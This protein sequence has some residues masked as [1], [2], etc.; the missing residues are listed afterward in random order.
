MADDIVENSPLPPPAPDKVVP[1][2][3]TSDKLLGANGEPDIGLQGPNASDAAYDLAAWRGAAGLKGDEQLPLIYRKMAQAR[4]QGFSWDE[5]N[6]SVN[7]RKQAAQEAGFSNDEINRSL[8]GVP[9]DSNPPAPQPGFANIKN[10]PAEFASMLRDLSDKWFGPH[11]PFKAMNLPEPGHVGQYPTAGGILK[12]L[13]WNALDFAKTFGSTALNGVA[14]V[15]ESVDGRDK[16]PWEWGKLGWEVA[17]LGMMLPMKGVAKG[18]PLP[19]PHEFLDRA[20]ELAKSHPTQNVAETMR[21]L[22]DHYI[23][24]G[25]HPQ[26]VPGFA[27]LEQ[28]LS[29]YHGSPHDFTLF[30]SSKALSG[31]GSQAFGAGHYVAENRDVG[32][33]YQDLAAKREQNRDNPEYWAK[34]A[35]ET[36]EGDNAK[37]ATYARE[38]ARDADTAFQG[39]RWTRAADL[40]EKN[41]KPGGNLYH[42]KVKAGAGELM[43]WDKPLSEQPEILK[44]INDA[45]IGGGVDDP[46]MTGGEWYQ[47]VTDPRS[48]EMDPR[49]L[50][51]QL[52][53]AGIPGHRFLDAGSRGGVPAENATRNM[54]IYNDNALEIIAKNGELVARG[55]GAKPA[56]PV[57]AMKSDLA[58]EDKIIPPSRVDNPVVET[59]VFEKLMADESGNIA[60]GPRTDIE[61]ETLF[62]HDPEIASGAIHDWLALTTPGSLAPNAGEAIAAKLAQT[63]IEKER[64]MGNIVRFGRAVGELSTPERLKL[65]DGIETGNLDEYK[66]KTLG[67]F[68]EQLR[69]ELDYWH[70]RITKA[71]GQLGYVQD[72]LPHIYAEPE[73]A[74]RWFQSRA[75]LAGG[76]AFTKERVFGT[77]AEAREAGLKM[78]SDNPIHIS[79]VAINQMS[80]YAAALD[81]VK[82]FR[83]NGLIAEVP[84]GEP[85][86]EGAVAIN[87]RLGVTGQGQLYAPKDAA[88]LINNITDKGLARY[89]LY[90][91]LRAYSNSQIQVQLGLSGYH[92]M[93][94]LQDTMT[95]A[96]AQ[97]V[98]QI[99]RGLMN[100]PSLETVAEIPRGLLTMAKAPLAPIENYLVGRQVINHLLGTKDGTGDIPI[101]SDAYREGGGRL[102]MTEDYRGS[103]YG[104]FLN[105]FKGSFMPSTGYATLGQ[106][107]GDLIR[108]SQ[109]MRAFGRDLR[110][111]WVPKVAFQLLGRTM[112]TAAAPIMSHLV[113][114]MK[115]GTFAM[116]MRDALR[117]APEMGPLEVRHVANLINKSMD[118]RMGEMVYDNRFWN[119]TIKDI[120]HMTVRALG[121][122]AGDIAELPGG[123]IDAAT[124]KTVRL[125]DMNQ[126]TYR[127]SYVAG[128]VAMTAMTGAII[129]YMT[130]NP[131]ETL[132]DYIFPNSPW[133]RISIPGYA[134]DVYNWATKP[135]DTAVGKLNP[136]LSQLTQMMSNRDWYG[137]VIYDWKHEDPITN[138]EDFAKW[139][140]S[141][142]MPISV[143]QQMQPT[144]EQR[145]IPE[146]MRWLGVNP[147]PYEVRNPGAA[148]HFKDQEYQKAVR[149]RARERAK[150]GASE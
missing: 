72:Y 55:E 82:D 28:Y 25:Q 145:E 21:A 67:A 3:T 88:L 22:G 46:S 16:T 108:N 62:Q 20:T 97:G 104:D 69:K 105:A 33:S 87:G 56:D 142:Y 114:T 136:M 79:A 42:V 83:K 70:Q 47:T 1:E 103:A 17:Q 92:A 23:N 144:P 98:Q 8:L 85:A 43:D 109:N 64:S 76:K 75:P 63:S 110:G 34:R 71:G 51:D 132:E 78:A 129:G 30:D 12:T 107:I 32:E 141:Q 6:D 74:S 9:L 19:K 125:G 124:G 4:A 111:T 14:A 117:V 150:A 86:P 18:E 29:A 146:A 119:K 5:I 126:V 53:E 133:G 118:N 38:Q 120:A 123:V 26:E 134:K 102:G 41:W 52:A 148:Q 130:G 10:A 140:G 80:R 13:G 115:A 39:A 27:D 49:A 94:I 77:Y 139:Y 31:E 96:L 65:I 54:V 113:P 11:D 149:K 135:G 48:G 50:S 61:P 36:N 66:G 106:E 143:K 147:A 84:H 73:Q 127:A 112:E 116:A 122:N 100:K 81:I 37:A 89:S 15:A 24:T 35:L 68:A 137:A 91:V 60:L 44:K 2:I 95:S 93:F 90:R 58:A 7:Q 121:W 128:F 57:E 40:L 45:K 131:P 59:P 101:L 99:S 138:I